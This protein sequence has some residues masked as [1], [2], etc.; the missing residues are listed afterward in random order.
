M[1]LLD[2]PGPFWPGLFK[3]LLA[4]GSSG[5]AEA[6]AFEQTCKAMH[7]IATYTDLQLEK[8]IS[9]HAHPLWSWLE[10]R[11][12]RI[13]G[14]TIH[15]YLAD[16]PWEGLGQAWQHPLSLL[17]RVPGLHLKLSTPETVAADDVALASAFLQQHGH[18]IS[19]LYLQHNITESGHAKMLPGLVP[20]QC[21]DV[22]VA[23]WADE[24]RDV[25]LSDLQSLAGKL[26][27]LTV[28]GDDDGTVVGLSTLLALSK[29]TYLYVS[30]GK[31]LAEPWKVLAALTGLQELFCAFQTTG[32]AAPLSVLTHVTCFCLDSSY[33]TQN[34]YLSTLQPLTALQQLQELTLGC[35][36]TTS[37]HGLGALTSLSEVELKDNTSLISL[38]GLNATALISLSLGNL[39]GI[40]SL[41]RL[42][43]LQCLRS[44]RIDGDVPGTTDLE[45]LSHLASL[46]DL[47]IGEISEEV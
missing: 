38:E 10:G 40:T 11:L 31:P 29:L 15:L 25:D 24:G 28:D 45:P 17:A 8:D 20:E 37:L 22:D 32:D 33:N 7:G 41:A 42:S 21:L 16:L 34:T 23:L 1:S 19:T 18:L 12:G 3:H 43:G 30:A 27:D 36:N 46:Q 35:F 5:L 26:T 9:D 47:A 2:L 44:L 6:A 13:S 14:L 4:A 39:P